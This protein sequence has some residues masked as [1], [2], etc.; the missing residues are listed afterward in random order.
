[1]PY[2][3]RDVSWM[4]FNRRLLLEAKKDSVPLLERLNFLGIYSNNLDEFFRVRVATLKRIVEF[5]GRSA[6]H[7]VKTAAETLKTIRRLNKIYAKDFDNTFE[8][9]LQKLHEE[10]V[11]L[12][13]E[14]DLSEEQIRQVKDFFWNKLHGSIHPIYINNVEVFNSEDDSL[15][16]FAVRMGN[17][18]NETFSLQAQSVIPLPVAEFGRFI[19]FENSNKSSYIMF[20]DDVI[21]FCLPIIFSGMGYDLFEAYT[22]KVTKDAEM[23]L[24]NDIRKGTLQ[25]ISKAA[26]ERNK[27]EPV[28]LVYDSDMPGETVRK[29][30]N[31][32]D[33]RRNDTKVPGGRYHNL[34]DLMKFPTC[35]R[36]DLRYPPQPPLFKPELSQTSGI[37]SQILKKDRFL[38][39]PY[40]SF[41]LFIR[42]LQEAALSKDVKS[43]DI[44]LYRVA[45]NSRV[46]Q[47]LIAA[48]QNGKKVTAVIELLARFDEESNIDWSQ[49]MENAGIKV[50]FGIESLKIHAKLVHITTRHGNIA[51]IGTG[52][53]H[54]GNAKAYTDYMLMTADKNL[55]REVSKV[56]SYIDRPYVDTRFP[57][58]LVS[59]NDM[60]KRLTQLINTE[61]RNKRLGK[62]AYIYIKVNHVTDPQIIK[63]LYE[64]ADAGVDI[65]MV[66][67][68]NCSIVT[69]RKEIQ[70]HLSVH[71]II[72]RYL[73]HSRMLIF[74]NGGNEKYYIGSADLM[75]R[76]L[77]NRIEILAPVYA[78]YIQEDIKRVIEYGWKDNSQSFVVNGLG[79]N[80][81]PHD[82]ETTLFRSQTALYAYYKNEIHEN[83]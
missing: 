60:R 5:A 11:D 20:L 61:I 74:A 57:E 16:Y 6:S 24:D 47:S 73:E 38:H 27:G 23:D 56:F 67:R 4:Y 72:D 22:F 82:N 66:V 63:K 51:C 48:A 2:V 77:D 80:N 83:K 7:E 28:R 34:K 15:L 36:P 9:V 43:I 68:G 71:G 21:R 8:M 54:E 44:S 59:P 30:C 75:P 29:L 78:P 18:L 46:I 53:L 70:E 1:M 49:K 52:N 41:D 76:N 17:S 19:V 12:V 13:S 32:L 64:A 81:R 62:P 58:L 79:D 26:K 55:T 40:H 50:I 65:K 10:K 37:L 69:Y 42:V 39:F 14:K 31:K 45:R 33:I 25:K 35:G 3:E